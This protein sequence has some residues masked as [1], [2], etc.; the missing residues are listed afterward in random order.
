MKENNFV[1]AVV[2]LNN[3]AGNVYDFLT[4]ANAVF[5]SNFK[6]WEF[7]CVG[8]ELEEEAVESIKKFKQENKNATVTMID[9][10]FSQ[11]LEAFMHAGI[12]LAIGDYIYEFD[13]CVADYDPALI[14]EVYKKAITGCDIAAAVPSRPGSRMLSKMFYRIY[15]CFSRSKGE[16]I[17]PE[18]FRILSRRAVNRT[19]AY[20]RLIPYRKAVYASSGLKLGNVI[21]ESSGMKAD[22][23]DR[24]SEKMNTAIDALVI[25]TDLAYRFSLGLSV[26]MAIFMVF[27]GV[28]TLIV[29]FGMNKPVEGWAPLMGM[30]SLA[31]FAVF[32][33]LTIIIKYLDVLLKLVFKK[34]K[35]LISSIEKL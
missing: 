2:C 35:Y 23:S 32:V 7:I 16:K 22:R 19:C 3:G 11:G 24:D 26:W 14:M 12:D 33:V 17:G 18:R 1:S 31:F 28:Y 8:A 5:K 27:A 20:G 34:Q 4:M 21:Y 15:N 6:N 25:F 29:Y 9:M 13:T 10:G 30:M